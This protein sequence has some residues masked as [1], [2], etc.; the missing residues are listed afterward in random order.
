MK[1]HFELERG[2]RGIVVPRAETIGREVRQPADSSMPTEST[3][4]T[5]IAVWPQLG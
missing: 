1:S 2:S 4:A 5:S 3:Y